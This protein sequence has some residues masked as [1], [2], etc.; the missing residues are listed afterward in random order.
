[1]RHRREVSQVARPA[2]HV[3]DIARMS[4]MKT[5]DYLYK[6]G[7]T[8]SARTKCQASP[9]PTSKTVSIATCTS[10]MEECVNRP[11]VSCRVLQNVERVDSGEEG[12]GAATDKAA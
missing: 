6:T 3:K 2:S 12:H 5:K 10:S 4:R 1:M 9:W 11:A 8:S 7:L